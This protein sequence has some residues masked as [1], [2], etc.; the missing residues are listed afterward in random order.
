MGKASVVV[1][2]AATAAAKA[3]KLLASIPTPSTRSVSASSISRSAPAGRSAT[4]L[5]YLSK[6]ASQVDIPPATLKN[7]DA[8]WKSALKKHPKLAALG[9]SAAGIAIASLATGKSPG[10]IIGSLTS[11]AL[12]ELSKAC[13]EVTGSS[14]VCDP[15]QLVTAGLIVVAV[16]VGWKLLGAMSSEQAA[17]P[18]PPP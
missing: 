13:E 3:R 1:S 15:G 10:E 12:G 5:R 2:G 4:D 8:A 16:V 14:V 18:P 11:G 17:P 7:A 6:N 9:I